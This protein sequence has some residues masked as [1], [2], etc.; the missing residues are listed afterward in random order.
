MKWLSQLTFFGSTQV[1]WKLYDGFYLA[2][3]RT[4]SPLWNVSRGWKRGCWIKIQHSTT[5]ITRE[6]PSGKI[7][8][9]KNMSKRSKP[10][11]W[12]PVSEK[13]VFSK[14]CST[15]PPAKEIKKMHL[16]H[17]KSKTPIWLSVNFQPWHSSRFC[18]FIH[19][20]SGNLRHAIFWET[21]QNSLR[22]LAGLWKKLWKNKGSWFF[23]FS[24]ARI[25]LPFS[26]T[27]SIFN[28]KW[29]QV[30]DLQHFPV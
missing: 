12:S 4:F 19:D 7:W 5:R 30:D 16:Q 18:R 3:P 11:S 23:G 25:S 26:V 28:F 20:Q 8:R 24:S 21:V 10:K 15:K 27:F 9:K 29:L 13:K 14:K 1:E 17:Q 22:E 2:C 6:R